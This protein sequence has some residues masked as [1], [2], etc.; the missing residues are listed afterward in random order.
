MDWAKDYHNKIA[1]KQQQRKDMLKNQTEYYKTATAKNKEWKLFGKMKNNASLGG[2]KGKAKAKV[3]KLWRRNDKI[4]GV[5]WTRKE[6]MA[7]ISGVKSGEEQVFVIL[8]EM[9]AGL[10][11]YDHI[12]VLSEYVKEIWEIVSQIEIDN[13]DVNENQE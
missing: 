8:T 7:V 10:E 12:D 2:V 1:E 13:G 6:F 5:G 3:L 11:E 9:I 4:D